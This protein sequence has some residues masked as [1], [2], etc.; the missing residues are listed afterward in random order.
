MDCTPGLITPGKKKHRG[1]L[2]VFPSQIGRED[3]REDAVL[4]ADGI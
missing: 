1:L 2:V 3:I 4:D